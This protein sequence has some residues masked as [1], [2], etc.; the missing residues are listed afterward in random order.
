[1][2]VEAAG[3]SEGVVQRLGEVGGGDDDDVAVLVEPV[4]LHQQLIKKCKPRLF[5]RRVEITKK[6]R[7][8]QHRS[9]QLTEGGRHWP[10][11]TLLDGSFLGYKCY[12]PYLHKCA[13]M[14]VRR[15]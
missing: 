13:L 15:I 11:V 4:H 10:G 9:G 8:I 7:G 12:A 2:L 14:L 3:A 1:M 5:P 6:V